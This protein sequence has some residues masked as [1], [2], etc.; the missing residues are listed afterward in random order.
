MNVKDLI[1]LFVLV[2]KDE[3]GF[4][5]PIDIHERILINRNSLNL[6]KDLH[7]ER[8]IIGIN[9]EDLKHTKQDVSRL[10]CKRLEGEYR[11]LFE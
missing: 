10:T 5:K 3:Y 2:K 11:R 9:N 1:N 6:I 8:K 4:I 7:T